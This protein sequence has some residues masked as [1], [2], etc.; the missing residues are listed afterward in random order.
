MDKKHT[1]RTAF[2]THCG[3]YEFLRLPFGLAG[4]PHTFQKVMEEMRQ[5]L[6]RSFLVYLDD[7]I[8]GSQ[9]ENEHLE[10][11]KAFLNVMCEVGMK[12]RAEKC[13]WRCSEIRYLGFLISEKG[14][15]MDDSDLKPILKLK[16]PENLAELRSLIGVFSYFIF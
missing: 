7:V 14:V 2:I 10:D 5:Q 9:T 15:R 1:E 3:L 6:S 16:K 8:L 12:L 4:A 13:R 11:L